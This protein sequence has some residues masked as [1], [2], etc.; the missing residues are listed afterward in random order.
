MISILCIQHFFS[1]IYTLNNSLYL[2]FLSKTFLQGH[3][4][5]FKTILL[6]F[7]FGCLGMCSGSTFCLYANI[8]ILALFLRDNFAGNLMLLAW[9]P[10]LLLSSRPTFVCEVSLISAFRLCVHSPQFHYKMC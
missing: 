7:P 3:I 4:S 5:L 1:F 10:F 8:F 9:L 6:K 2:V